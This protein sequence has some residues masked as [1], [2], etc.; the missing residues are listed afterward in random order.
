MYRVIAECYQA[1]RSKA[2]EREEMKMSLG[3]PQLGFADKSKPLPWVHNL[4]TGKKM[5]QLAICEDC[6]GYYVLQCPCNFSPE[7]DGT[8]I[9][10]AK[11]VKNEDFK[12]MLESIEGLATKRLLELK[13]KAQ[14]ELTWRNVDEETL[15]KGSCS[16]VPK[17]A[18]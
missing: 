2:E 17:I 10:R 13:E 3:N 5:Y 18:S 7:G 16:G 4:L 1:R 14:E 11:E 12:K 9:I 6:G 8:E 15:D